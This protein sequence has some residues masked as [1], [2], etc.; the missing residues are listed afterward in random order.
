M[1]AAFSISPMGGQ[2]DDGDGGV[3]EAV[4]EAVALPALQHLGVRG[5]DAQLHHVEGCS[6]GTGYRGPAAG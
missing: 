4:A 5:T 1:L 3:S 2:H 6:H